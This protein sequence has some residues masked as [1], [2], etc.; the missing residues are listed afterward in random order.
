MDRVMLHGQNVAYEEVAGS[1]PVLLLVHGVG[2]SRR[3]WDTV[4]PWLAEQG[5]HLV[6]V[7][8]P[9]HGDS[10]KGRG[11]YSLGAFA[12]TLRDLLDHLGHRTAVLA[13]HS[14]GGGIALQFA[15]QYPER[16]AGLVLVAS[17]GL[18]REASLLLRVAT[19]PGSE[20]VLPLIAH[21]RTV[22]AIVAVDRG[23]SKARG[24]PPMS[25]DTIA[26]LTDLAEAE[27]RA[28]FLST[29]R[30]VV[31]V[32]GQ[33]VSAVP[34]LTSASHLPI[35]LVWGDRDAI[36]PMVH[37]RQALEQL[38]DGRLVVFPGAGH[39]PHRH[40]PERFASLLISYTAA[41]AEARVG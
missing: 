20:L 2:S 13:G 27:N 30:S 15:Y 31:D 8:L 1:G 32:S 9:G 24:T 36:I 40:D 33:R 14:L 22:S 38:P 10:D 34:K 6:L 41:A 12:S 28:A 26:T 35:L 17:G 11:D 7:D 18:G 3:T 21:P 16:C 23:L 29:L 4:M 37:G 5:A 19:L 25:H 39:E